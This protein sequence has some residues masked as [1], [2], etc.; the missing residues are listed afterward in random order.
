MW[1]KEAYSRLLTDNHITDINPLFMSKFSPSEYVKEVKKSGVESAM[2]YAVCH[3][4]NCYYPSKVG[5]IH[6]NIKEDIFGKVVEGLNGEGIIPIAYYT[7]LHHNDFAKRFPET[8]MKD[9][10]GNC[11]TGRYFYSCPNN[12]KS[13]N[14]YK[15]QIKEILSYPIKG[16]FIDMTFWPCV[17]VCD[18]CKEKYGKPIPSLIDW[19]DPS[20]VSFQRFREE[21]MASFGE[22]LTDFCKELRPDITVTHQFSPMLHGWFLGQSDKIAKISDYCSGDFY[23]DKIQQRFGIKGFDALTVNKPFEFMTSRC[24]SLYDHT[25]CKSDEEL[26]LSAMTTL[27]NGGAYFFIDAINP[28]GT[29]ESSFYD[30]LRKINEY[31]TPFRET[32]KE[33][34]FH[35]TGD[36]GLYFSMASCVDLNING[37]KLSEFNPGSSSNMSVRKNAVLD[38]TIASAELLTEMH[39]PY[40]V[41][42]DTTLDYKG[43]KTIIIHNSRFLSLEICERLREFVAG[44]GN[45]IVTGA[46][47]ICDYY[48]NPYGNF[49]LGDLMGVDFLHKYSPAVNYTGKDLILSDCEAPLGK[50]TRAK[51]LAYFNFPLYPVNDV[52]EYASIHSNPPGK[53]TEYPAVTENSYGKGKCMWISAPFILKKQYTQKEF[54]KKLY[55]KYIKGPIETDLPYSVEITCLEGNGKKAL[56]VVNMQDQYP[57]LPLYNNRILIDMPKPNKIIKASTGEEALWEYTE[58]R[59][60]ITTDKLIF[61]EFYVID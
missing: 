26:I 17:C 29:L 57:P 14:L 41:V 35:I 3:N 60:K 10:L 53:E 4:G 46:T 52:F 27:A 21:S 13:V 6:K 15:E 40:R 22:K 30:R 19:S 18:A 44:G 59:V 11:H 45:L 38:E 32:V 61:G 7:V 9:N 36:V 42:T 58:N 23:G 50:V 8:A 20:W 48:G 43:F 49:A 16:I 5:H 56:C 54:A 51:V 37:T 25:S 31:L 47:G 12:E 34:A 24:V 33:N 28:D 2:V 55:K 39:V 1:I